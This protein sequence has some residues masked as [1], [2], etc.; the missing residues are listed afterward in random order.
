[1]LAINF[2]HRS[3]RWSNNAAHNAGVTCVI[4]GIGREKNGKYIYDDDQRQEVKTINPY[5][6]PSNVQVVET[7]SQPISA[8]GKMS[9]GNLPGDGNFLTLT[10][11]ERDALL[12]EAPHLERMIIR[13]FGAQEFIRGLQRFCL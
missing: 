8:I 7:S 11:A 4:L 9:Y 3:F 12:L 2:A 5:L 13:L 1:G 6:L 10:R